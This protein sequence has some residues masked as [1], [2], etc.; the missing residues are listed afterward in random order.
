MNQ[1]KDLEVTLLSCAAC[2]AV[3]PDDALFC[4]HCGAPASAPLSGA[5]SLLPAV[6]GL[7]EDGM[8]LA[9][10]VASDALSMV[11]HL[12]RDKTR[13]EP[14]DVQ[15][16]AEEDIA[17]PYYLE[18]AHVL[19]ASPQ[20]T[21]I[22]GHFKPGPGDQRC[23]APG[24]FLASEERQRHTV[25]GEA[26]ARLERQLH[27]PETA[28]D[29][30]SDGIYLGAQVRH[31]YLAT[32]ATCDGE[33]RDTCHG[34]CGCGNEECWEC[35]GSLRVKCKSFNC[36][37]GKVNCNSCVGRGYTTRIEYY[38]ETIQVPVTV[39][40]YHSTGTSQ[41]TEYHYE[42]VSRQREV[43]D[44]CYFCQGGKV[45]CGSCNG[46]DRVQCPT[47]HA[48]GTVRC[49]TCGGSGH[50]VCSPCAGSGETGQ[51]SAVSVHLATAYA[52]EQP[53][54]MPEDALQIAYGEGAHALARI[55]DA[56][57]LAGLAPGD[58]GATLVARY[59]MPVRLVRLAAGCGAER[60]DLVAY[61]RPLRWLTLDD[62]VEDLLQ[63][64]LRALKE[65]LA[66]MADDG[67]FASDVDKLL[68][69]LRHVAAS[70][71]NAEVVES[72]LEG[73]G[74]SA[75][76]GV[77]SAQY[78][79]DIEAA[80]LGTLRHAYTRF[81]KRSWW[82]GALASALLLLGGWLWA[83]L[84][85]G[86]AL[87]S[88]ALPI[89]VWMFQRR[90]RATLGEALG[91]ET[92]AR[93]AMALARKGRR[94]RAAL[95]MLLAPTVLLLAC[96]VW[97]LPMHSPLPGRAAV[98]AAAPATPS[99]A[100]REA[101]APVLRSHAAGELE[102]ARASL[103]ILAGEGNG[104]AYGPYAWMVLLGEGLTPG[105]IA[106]DDM[107]ERV[108]AAREWAAKAVELDDAWGLAT[109]GMI[110]VNKQGGHFDMAEGLRKLELAAG[111]GHL[112]AMHFLGMIHY[113]GVNVPVDHAQARTW[114]TQ[115]A[116]RDDATAL[117]NL[118][119]MDWEGNGIARPDRTSAMKHW[120]RAAALG[121]ELARRAVVK[122]RPA[123]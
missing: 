97:A 98:A 73:K 111:R 29:T 44:P 65:A 37:F 120:R 39:T 60:Y 70:E 93:R 41:R 95:V 99:A 114:F 78:A 32:C 103:R 58:D 96:A 67:V 64:D 71:L 46:T 33:G 121:N 81:A 42:N 19:D 49:R 87:A 57:S 66:R 74:A 84:L 85:P 110:Q 105:E 52:I 54:G 108:A 11:R 6:A 28:Y 104:A 106:R 117:Y 30:V 55:S 101:V 63:R 123:D 2:D 13:F 8:A 91:S 34:C 3:Y 53:D 94:D 119:L 77:V 116:Q 118:G 26:M 92:Q 86:L 43:Q 115:A 113:K 109:Q 40:D 75:H 10:P 38:S 102:S 36:M 17:Y 76:A 51:S 62:M 7:E 9:A 68:A 22:T 16:I 59:A 107:R 69:P 24:Q 90:M 80:V 56:I 5:T 21:A 25:L 15:A 82:H 72:V 31:H 4:D 48:T 61:G 18:V 45:D 89:S 35:H 47:C 79:S 20:R 50:L 1:T 88:L 122:R 23:S 100:E 83:G 12:V 14:H 27:E 112:G